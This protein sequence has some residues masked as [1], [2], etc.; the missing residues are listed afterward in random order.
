MT[1]C[2]KKAR[3]VRVCEPKLTAFFLHVLEQTRIL[4][5]DGR[6]VRERLHQSDDGLWELTS[7]A[8]SQRERTQGPLGPEQRN[9]QRCAKPRVKQ[10]VAQAITGTL[11]KVRDL[12]WLPLG[13]RFAKTRL[14]RRHVKL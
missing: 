13:N 6:L 3:F 4:E 2:R 5:R 11:H 7:E 8:S 9:D 14:S 1:S 10:R 12:H